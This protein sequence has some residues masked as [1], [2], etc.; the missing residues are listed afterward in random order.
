MHSCGPTLLLLLPNGC[1]RPAAP[2]ACPWTRATSGGG[3]R[4]AAAG[5]PPRGSGAAG[6]RLCPTNLLRHWLCRMSGEQDQQQQIAHL[7]QELDTCQ[8]RQYELEMQLR[9]RDGNIEDLQS[10]LQQVQQHYDD[11]RQHY[12]DLA[13][14]LRKICRAV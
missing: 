11:L 4:R 7:R 13:Q 6:R 3:G 5:R 12:D 10:R 8:A 2:S 1:D 9:I 14:Q